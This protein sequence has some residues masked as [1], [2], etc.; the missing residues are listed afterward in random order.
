MDYIDA[1][2]GQLRF[3][4]QSE[5]GELW[6]AATPLCD[7]PYFIGID[8]DLWTVDELPVNDEETLIKWC[9][10]CADIIYS[11]F[12]NDE[13]GPIEIQYELWAAVQ[14]YIS[15]NY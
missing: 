2:Q 9:R 1:E 13:F 15:K 3:A 12:R 14:Y 7:G 4:L 11:R 10:N 8:L 5:Q 6:V